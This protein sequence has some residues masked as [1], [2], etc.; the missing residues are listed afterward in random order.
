MPAGTFLVSTGDPYTYFYDQTC[1]DSGSCATA[2]IYNPAT[3]STY[4]VGTKT[5]VISAS[6]GTRMQSNS[7]SDTVCLGSGSN[8][9]RLCLDNQFFYSVNRI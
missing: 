7:A 1:F 9:T 6:T 3:S 5:N 2:P 8:S 4:R